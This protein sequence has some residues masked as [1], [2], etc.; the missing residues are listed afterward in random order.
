[1]GFGFP[2]AL[3]ALILVLLIRLWWFYLWAVGG[4]RLV[5]VSWINDY[6][7]G[8]LGCTRTCGLLRWSITGIVNITC[9]TIGNPIEFYLHW[10]VNTDSVCLSFSPF[11]LLF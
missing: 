11:C 5:G 3:L 1:M 10:L 7:L 4:E 2:V 9:L 8:N 6:L